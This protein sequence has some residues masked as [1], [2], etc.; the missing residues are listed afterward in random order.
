MCGVQS[1]KAGKTVFEPGLLARAHRGVLYVDDINL[2]DTELSNILLS[3]VSDGWVNVEREG[4]SVRYPCRPLLVA[5][6]NPEEA[7]LRS[8]LLDRIAVSLSADA[9]PLSLQERVEAVEATTGF[10]EKTLSSESV[11]KMT[12]LEDGLK[13]QILFAREELKENKLSTKQ[14]EYLCGEASRAGVQGHRAEIFACEVARANAALNSR[15]PNA[16]DL[17]LA[18]KLVIA[19]RSKFFQDPDMMEEMMQQQ[20]PPPPPPQDQMEQEEDEDADEMDEPDKENEDQEEQA[21]PEPE[22]PQEF[23][24]DAEDTVMDAELLN[25][26]TKQTS[27]SSGGRG[28]IFSKE[29]GRYIKA[30]LPRGKVTRLAVDATMRASAPYQA[31]RRLRAE[32]DPNKQKRKVYIENSDVRVKRMV[33]KAGALVIFAVDASGSM[34][35]NRMNAAKGACMSLLSEAYQSRDKI[36]LI[37]FQGDEAE[38]LLPPTRSIAMAKKRLETMPCGGGSPLAHALTLAMRTGINAQK[39]GDVGK[40]VVVAITDGRANV[41]LAVSMEEELLTPEMQKDKAA[42]KE[43]V[44]AVARQMRGLSSFNFVVLDTENKFVSTGVAKELA[45][46]AGGRYHYIPKADD[47]S[48]AAV[49]SQAIS[50]FGLK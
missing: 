41:P 8:H 50:S 15:P 21:E 43:E 40:V 14:I 27:G 39:S 10:A 35:L 16:D 29:R 1:V 28:L 32:A 46:A 34:A 49:A 36:C 19:P 45:E 31:P 17:K 2:L 25:F 38:V 3:V 5:T 20:P 48:I 22:I 24:F 13:T 12:E 30:M 6:F 37:P 18:V 7:E 4:T 44:L 47:A 9:N 26:M 33:R 23:M 42:L 11:E